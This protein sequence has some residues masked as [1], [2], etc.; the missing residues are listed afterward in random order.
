MSFEEFILN[1]IGRDN[2]KYLHEYSK[3]FQ[4][5]DPKTTNYPKVPDLCIVDKENNLLFIEVKMPG[6][7][8]DPLQIIGLKMIKKYLRPKERLNI[9]AKKVELVPK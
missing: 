2:L 5:E 1:I 6:D 7:S 9:F 4:G 3:I 8:F